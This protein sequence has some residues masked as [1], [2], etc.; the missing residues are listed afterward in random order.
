M[1]RWAPIAPVWVCATPSARSRSGEVPLTTCSE[2]GSRTCR[3]RASR[4]S[5]SLA[6]LRGSGGGRV[7]TRRTVND[8]VLRISAQRNVGP[9]GPTDPDRHLDLLRLANSE[10]LV[11]LGLQVGH[12]RELLQ[13]LAVGV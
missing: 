9:L 1:R 12:F 6:G 11:E 3:R 2:Q 4:R 10:Q 7:G 5:R 8:E 13:D